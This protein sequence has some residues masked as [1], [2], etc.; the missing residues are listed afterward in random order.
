MK[1]LL[2]LTALSA[3]FLLSDAAWASEQTVTLA[4]DNMTCASCPFIVKKTL[5]VVPGVS[6]VEV[7]FEAKSVTV[8]FDDQKATVAA[9]AE[10]TTKVGY[11]SKLAG[12]KTQ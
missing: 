7:S 8:T 4:V 11:P 9:L 6:K 10:A 3:G 1:Y 5:A 2:S 12:A